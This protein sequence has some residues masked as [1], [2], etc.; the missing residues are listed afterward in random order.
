MKMTSFATFEKINLTFPEVTIE[1]HFEKISFRVRKKIFATYDEKNLS[2]TVKLSKSDQDQFSSANQSVYPVDNKWG[3]QGWTIVEL[4]QVDEGL[5]YGILT[6]AYR[7]VA[8]KKLIELMDT[9]E[10]S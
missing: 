3:E 5:L 9:D 2:A 8:P 7:E 10:N 6:S 1:P 4:A